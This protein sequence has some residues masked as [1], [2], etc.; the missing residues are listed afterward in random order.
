M[1]QL[2]CS[3]VFDSFP[4]VQIVFVDSFPTIHTP[5]QPKE[6]KGERLKPH[7]LMPKKSREEDQS[8]NRIDNFVVYISRPKIILHIGKQISTRRRRI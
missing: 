8:R 4:K 6:L 7:E 5:L 2:G 1:A 3:I